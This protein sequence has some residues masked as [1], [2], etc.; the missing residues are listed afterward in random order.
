MKAPFNIEKI[1]REVVDSIILNPVEPHRHDH[2]ELIIL[3]H[4][5]PAHSID[6]K[7]EFLTPPVIVYV[8]Q[9]K[10]HGFIPDEH[11]RGWVIRYTSVS[12]PKV[13]STSILLSLMTSI[14]NWKLIFAVPPCMI[15]VKSC[16]AKMRRNRSITP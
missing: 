8:A 11:T 9:G 16:F 5:H 3:T 1:T 10:V 13:I 12:Y 15:S 6:F 4:G 14:S 2:E 7:S